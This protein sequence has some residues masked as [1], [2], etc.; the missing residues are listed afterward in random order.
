MRWALLPAVETLPESTRKDFHE[1]IR[2]RWSRVV[3]IAITFLLLS[4]IVNIISMENQY[5]LGKVPY[6][7]LLFGI[8]FLLA[9]PVFFL[10]SVLTGRS[11]FG[12]RFRDNRK[13]W[14]TVSVVLALLIVCL[15]G[16]LRKSNPPRKPVGTAQTAP[17]A[18]PAGMFLPNSSPLISLEL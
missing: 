11:A 4:G 3:Q 1:A 12:Q 13:L 14:L 16:I 9:L 2:S 7:R 15:S 5:D 17:A 8:K 6:Y 18:A 10:A